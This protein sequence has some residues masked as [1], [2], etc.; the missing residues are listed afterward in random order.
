[1]TVHL[2]FFQR[3][4]GQETGDITWT[5][6]ISLPSVQAIQYKYT[7]G[8]WDVNE[9]W[10][11][12]VSVNNR[13]ATVDYGSNG[14]QLLD[15]VV[16]YW[17]DPLVIAHQPADGAVDLEPSLVISVT[18]SHYLDPAN[19]NAGN[20]VLSSETSTPILDMD[21]DYHAEMTAT[22]ILLMPTAALDEGGVCRMGILHPRSRRSRSQAC[23]VLL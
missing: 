12:I 8:T 10:G 6:A 2:R 15:D 11:P 20:L 7:R 14:S 4:R 16:H 19:I 22:T 1:M 17:R 23:A 21:F 3:T 18:V 5:K 13:H 9:W